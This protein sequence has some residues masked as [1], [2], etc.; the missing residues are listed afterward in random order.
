M[1]YSPHDAEDGL[2]ERLKEKYGSINWVTLPTD[3]DF[4]SEDVIELVKY[5]DKE[6]IYD[7]FLKRKDTPANVL[8]VMGSNISEDWGTEGEYGDIREDFLEKICEHPNV[9][10]A[11]LDDLTGDIFIAVQGAAAA[12]PKTSINLVYDI[13]ERL[14]KDLEDEEAFDEC[15]YEALI[16]NIEESLRKRGYDPKKRPGEKEGPEDV[17]GQGLLSFMN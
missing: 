5:F 11:I 4:P 1:A 3:T 8:Q 2:I 7:Y 6:D 17:P 13:L 16:D 12:N 14:K 9:S 10:T 15:L